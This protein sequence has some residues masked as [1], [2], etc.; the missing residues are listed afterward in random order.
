MCLA[1]SVPASSTSPGGGEACQAAAA[2]TGTLVLVLQCTCSEGWL[3]FVQPIRKRTA[4]LHA[5]VHSASTL[6]P[7]IFWK[8]HCW[9]PYTILC[10]SHGQRRSAV[11][12]PEGD[13]V[14]PLQVDQ[15]TKE[16]G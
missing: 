9:Q 12:T 5:A 7:E 16:A 4:R 1:Q 14:Q 2:R 6:S 3:Q 15:R 11:T 13:Q 10:C 8:S